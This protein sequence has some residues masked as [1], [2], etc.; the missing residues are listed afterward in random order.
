MI[1]ELKITEPEKWLLQNLSTPLIISGPCSAESFVQLHSTAKALKENQN[2]HIF[3]AGIWKP[4]TRPGNFE[5]AG[6][7]GLKWLSEI[8]KE[9]NF[10]IAVEA[11]KPE[12]IELCMKYDIDV[13]WIGART[14]SN[15]FSVQELCEALNGTDKTILVKNPVNPDLDLW[16]GA[17]ERL[18]KAGIT[19]IGAIFRGFYPYEKTTLRNIPKWE[20]AIELK[21]RFNNL[22]VI[23]DPSHIS[24]TV[25]YIKDISQKALD[26]NFDGLMIE[27]HINPKE[28]LSDSKQQLK[29]AELH[30]LLNTLTYRE[31]S[32]E[33]PEYMS[34]IEQYREKVDSIDIQLLDLL[35]SRMKIIE[36]IGKYKK[37]NNVTIFQ[38]RRWE[39]ILKTRIE[40]GLRNGLSLN[41]IK[42]ILE[43]VHNESIS[44]QNEIMNNSI[45]NTKKT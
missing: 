40:Y 41:F 23:C 22:P 13:I 20:V 11:A 7:E 15:P 19:K 14:T 45:K 6:E 36:E 32:S 43:I 8:K 37:A 4:R 5:G 42:Q 16:I 3:R 24:G 39:S 26:L 28:A 1:S 2:V 18:N 12:H 21:S 9:F 30:N 44:V 33:N 25:K 34:L 29:P 35:G 31:A 17:F 38:L 10:P 27:S